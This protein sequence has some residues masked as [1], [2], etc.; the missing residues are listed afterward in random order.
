MADERTYDVVVLG[1]GPPGENAAQVA[2]NAGLSAAVVESE[3]IG[4][5]CSYYACMPSKALL[6]PVAALAGAKGV[7]GSR[8]AVTG[9]LDVQAVLARRDAF[10]S[11]WDDA[12]QVDWLDG[13]GVDLVRGHARITAERT[14][15][16]ES[17]AGE[18]VTLRAHHAVVVSTGSEAAVP[19][20][21]GLREAR[22]WTSREATTAKFVPPRLAIIGGGVVGC[23]M[24]DAYTAF[25]SAV[26]MLVRDDRLLTGVEPFAGE[27]V[28]ASLERRGAD[29]RLNA[30]ASAVERRDTGDEPIVVLTASD[31]SA[32]EADEVLVATGRAPRTHGIGLDA[33]GLEDGAWIEVDDT[34]LATGVPGGWL[35]AIGD[36]NRRALLTHMGKY[37]AR[38]SG[39]AI[40]ARAR[41]ERADAST[42]SP[43]AA[44]ADHTAVPQVIFTH[45]EVAAVGRTEQQARED[46]LTVRAVDYSIGNVAGGALHADGYD[47]QVHAV[48]DEDRRVLVGVTLTG[49]DVGEMLHAATIAVTG[50]VPIDRLWHAV[51]AFP[52]M[53]ELWLR[54]LETYGS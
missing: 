23:E 11:H 36:V 29:I 12:G 50:E 43:T 46:G 42:W 44:T 32:I 2:V 26:T 10:A 39:A 53:S 21:P 22:P 28:R 35:Y 37:Q 40:V 7:D 48:V 18:P 24:A 38:A 13:A 6:R 20:I 25:G 51:P 41:G 45:P 34:C 54:L 16:V 27:A 1:A 30:N 5:E 19:A 14:V 47:G 31:G 33:V 17:G 8:Q 3:L 4:G 15:V 49:A 52:T 9:D